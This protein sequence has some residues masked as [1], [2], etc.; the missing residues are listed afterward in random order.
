MTNHRTPWDVVVVG[1]GMAGLTAAVAARAA[2]AATLVLEKG[3][4]C[5][6][7][8]ALSAGMF[9]GS[10]DAAGLRAYI[11]DGDPDLQ[12]MMCAE[13]QPSLEWLEALA[14]PLG[15]P[16]GFGDF[17]TV[18]PMGLGKP[19]D[20]RP[21][22]DLYIA[23]AK[24]AGVEIRSETAMTALRPGSDGFEISTAG[25]DT[26]GA[27]AVVLATGGF[28]GDRDRLRTVLGAA[29]A[30]ALFLRSRP[31]AS[32]DGLRTAEALG[33]ATAGT[34]DAF[35]GHTILDLP[36]GPADWQRLTPYF[37]RG[38]V[39]VNRDGVR[40]TD[41]GAGLLEETNAQDGCR[42]PGGIYWLVFDRGI[43]DAA[44]EM[45]GTA[46]SLADF[47][48]VAEA[49]A[50]GATVHEQDDLG[51]L[52]AALEGEGVDGASFQATI[53]RYNVACRDG[54]TDT[55]DPVRSPPFRP[56]DT[57]PFFGVRCRAAITG[58]TGGIAVDENCRVLDPRGRPIGALFAAGVDVGGYFGR[59]YNGFL[60]WALV[61]GR[62]AG[63]AAAREAAHSGRPKPS[64]QSA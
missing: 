24:D 13:Y 35:Y 57:P 23:R 52:T 31:E 40:F 34:L 33:A 20:R 22:L 10:S 38:S 28:Q 36:L 48:W 49:R 43:L 6:G 60:G 16:S 21:W 46:A 39:L 47:D 30:E 51:G 44:A 11:P 56:I 12:R 27:R 2:G 9:L 25:G 19:G 29:A 8:A 15:E 42:Q 18:R 50:V 3:D 62:R 54:A 59:T 26:V 1:G 45:Q 32:G 4:V 14:M 55:L 64:H 5:G 17:R 53:E 61:S 37:S 7:N 41:E 63:D 58:T